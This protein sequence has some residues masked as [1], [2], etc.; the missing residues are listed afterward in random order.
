[1]KKLLKILSLTTIVITVLII[2]IFGEK[3]LSTIAILGIE[4]LLTLIGIPL[5]VSTIK[6]WSKK[7]NYWDNV[8]RELA[9]SRVQ[10]KKT[11]VTEE[12]KREFFFPDE[13]YR[14]EDSGFL[15][16]LGEGSWI[17]SDKSAYID[18]L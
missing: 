14:I 7:E 3:Y 16:G 6:D 4:F 11:E 13:D 2:M 8:Q 12:Q 15:Y 1:M 10:T 18:Y 9:E 5:T 17:L